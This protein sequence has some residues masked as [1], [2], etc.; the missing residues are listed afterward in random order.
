MIPTMMAYL[1]D[2]F[3]Y[4]QILGPMTESSKIS[5]LEV[6]I[7]CWSNMS[8]IVLVTR[9]MCSSPENIVCTNNDPNASFLPADIVAC[10]IHFSSNACSIL[11]TVEAG[12]S[13]VLRTISIPQVNWMDN[14]IFAKNIHIPNAIIRELINTH[15]RA[16]VI[17]E[18]FIV[19]ISNK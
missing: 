15:V 14:L 7:C 17:I 8:S 6:M 12:I 16:C 11:A 2:F 9:L 1:A 4:S 3:I 18:N 5:S 13:D 10:A 19:H